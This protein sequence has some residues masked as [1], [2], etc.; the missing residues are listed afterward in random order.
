MLKTLLGKDKLDDK[1]IEQVNELFLSNYEKYH[2]NNLINY[3]G[4][5]KL[6]SDTTF[7]CVLLVEEDKV[8]GF[9]GFYLKSK[10]ND[11]IQQYLLAHLLVDVASRGK[12]YGK[13]LEDSRLDIIENIKREK[14]IYASCVEK[15]MNSINMKLGRGFFISGFRYRYRKG[16]GQRE[17][18]LVLTKVKKEKN[19]ICRISTQSDMTKRILKVGNDS[20]EFGD[21]YNDKSLDCYNMVVNRDNN[22]DRTVCEIDYNKEG[23]LLSKL[24][25]ENNKSSK[26][27]TSI[28]VRPSIVGFCKVDEYLIQH[29]FYPICYLPYVYDYYGVLEYQYLPDGIDK[30]ILDKNVSSEGKNFLKYIA[31]KDEMY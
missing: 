9:A 7:D 3:N 15:P 30:V 6:L 5:R 16:G 4:L 21:K 29:N 25:S 26:G 10:E 22:S 18:S 24:I 12:G 14:V 20:I 27:Y 13:L 2:Y 1:M 31:G 11:T 8:C 17:N 19:I 28:Y 23:N